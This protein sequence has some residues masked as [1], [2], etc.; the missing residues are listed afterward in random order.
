MGSRVIPTAGSRVIPDVGLLSGR[1]LGMRWKILPSLALEVESS[2]FSKGRP[3]P[4]GV[5]MVG[6]R[7][8][9]LTEGVENFGLVGLKAGLVTVLVG[10]NGFLAVDA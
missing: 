10:E 6:G 3:D 7:I 9:G 5:A 2:S 8:V 4:A 1:S